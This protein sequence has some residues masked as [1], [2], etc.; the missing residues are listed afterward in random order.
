MLGTE[1][2]ICKSLAVFSE[3]QI[4]KSL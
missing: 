4:I 3:T 1:Q 2:Y